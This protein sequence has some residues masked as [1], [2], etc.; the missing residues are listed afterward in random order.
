MAYSHVLMFMLGGKMGV[1]RLG[2]GE[3]YFLLIKF[4]KI[5]YKKMFKIFYMVPL[6]SYM[7]FSP[8][9]SKFFGWRKYRGVTFLK[10]LSE[11]SS[12]FYEG[13]TKYVIWG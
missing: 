4:F 11:I 9:L 7:T 5:L 6:G 3:H 13:V 1:G 12:P 8:N 10:N 2:E